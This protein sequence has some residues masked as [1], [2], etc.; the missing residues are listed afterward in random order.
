[1]KIVNNYPAVVTMDKIYFDKLEFQ[2]EEN[3]L[4]DEL[5]VNFKK[6][7]DELAGQ[8][9]KYSVILQ[10]TIE[11]QTHHS[12]RIFASMVGIFECHSEDPGLLDTLINE[13]TVAIMFPFLRSQISLMTTQP[14]MS[15]VILPPMNINNLLSGIDRPNKS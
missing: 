3:I 7:V 5:N 12:L 14:D 10:C 6:S 15:P 2:R 9:N 8:N 13:N 11:D 1:M 4:S